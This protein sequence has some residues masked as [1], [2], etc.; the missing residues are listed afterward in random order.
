MKKTLP[1]SFYR[2]DTKEVAIDLLG[3]ILVRRTQEGT[4]KGKIVETEAYYGPD[5]PASH[6]Y[7]GMTKRAQIMWGSPG[8][9]YVYF[10]YGMHYLLNVVT[11][12]EGK[13]GAVLIRA[14][15]PKEGIELMKRRRNFCDLK[16]L[17]NGPAK[18]TQ[19]FDI[20]TRENGV[21]LT[22]RKLWIEEGSGEKFEVV[23]TSRIGIRA[24][25]EAKL[26][27]YIKGNEFVSK[28]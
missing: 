26:R 27:F 13:A 8:I 21:D 16:N 5:D 19:A 15:E 4:V 6:A 18:L 14:L 22:G 12:E 28:K 24:G 25:K 10:T 17:T 11:E 2:R 1:K 20:T 3:K 9:A 23:S 7:K